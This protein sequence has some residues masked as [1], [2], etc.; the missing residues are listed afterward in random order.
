[1]ALLT[2]SDMTVKFDDFTAVDS[3]SFSIES[4]QTL[5]VVGESGSGKSV[6]ALSIMRLVE[7]GTRAKITSGSIEFKRQDGT[8]LDLLHQ[9]EESMRKIRGNEISM[10]FQE[11]LTSL[12]PVYPVGEQIAEAVRIHEGL[13][14]RAAM[15][16]ARE[17]FDLVRIP[18]A[19]KRIGQY[20]HEMSGGMRQRVMIGIALACN[21][22]LL[23]ADEPTTALDVTIQAQILGLIRQLQVDTGTAV[24]LITHDMGVVAESADHVVVMNRSKVVETGDVDTIFHDPKESYTQGL[25][26]AVPQLGS[27]AGKSEPEPFHLAGSLK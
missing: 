19:D 22:R 6:T 14:R 9:D 24:M 27:M 11:P 23:I 5:A 2:V 1:M 26:S 21:P 25:L 8:R 20:P 12:N 18:E 3:A 16:R 13:D 15:A 7:L 4:G 17:M 10:I